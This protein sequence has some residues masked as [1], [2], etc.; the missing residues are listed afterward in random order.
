VEWLGRVS[1]A[2]KARRLRGATIYCAPSLR[3]ESFGVVLL[4]AMAAGV[5]S[6]AS[7]IPGYRA[8]ARPDQ[9]ALIVP[10]GDVD[11]LRAA[12]TRLL[13]DAGLRADLVAAGKLRAA[14]LSMARLAERMVPIYERAIRPP[15]T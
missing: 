11:A 7:D 4:E 14:E 2:E 5:A 1:D 6:V 10:P 12:L 15:V 9:E 13:D 3:G 8:V